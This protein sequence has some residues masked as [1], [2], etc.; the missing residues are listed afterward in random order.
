MK[1]KIQR[2]KKNN[3][4]F[5]LFSILTVF[6]LTLTI[7]FSASSSMLAINGGALVRSSADVRIT[8]VQR[9]QESSDVTLKS[10]SLDSNQSFSLDCRLTTIWSKAYFEITVTNLSSTP[11]LV[12]G[13]EKLQELNTHMDYSM[14]DFVINKTKIPPASEAKI[15]IC[16]QYK[17]DFADKYISGNLEI[18][19]QW[20]NPE[21]SNLKTSLKLNFY[22]VPQYNYTINTN[23]TD[24]LITLEDDSGVIATGNG[25]LTSI[26]DEN[27]TVKWTVTRKNYYP[28]TGTEVVTD[29]VVKEITMLRT[30]DKIFT[31]VPTP[32]DALVTIKKKS[33]DTVLASGI[34]TQSIAIGDLTELSYSV[35]RLE[36][37]EVTGEYTLA[38]EDYTENV[39]LEEMP[40]AT[41]TFVNTDRK[42]ETTKEDTIYHP[43]YYLIEIWGGKG[44]SYLRSSSKSVGY[45]GTAG[46]I[47]GVVNLE[48][49]SKIYFTLGGDG[50]EG[51]LSGT[52]RGGANGGGYGGATYSG[53]AG[54]YS[55]FAI[56]TTTIDESN[57][58][59]G[60]VLLIVGGG[61]GGG[62][63]SL[64][65]GKPGDGGNAG[66][67][68]SNKT[69]IGIGTVFYGADGTLNDAKKGHNGLGGITTARTQTNA[70]DAGALLA[71]GNGSGNGG[72]GGAGYY[73]GG[74]GGG[75]GTLSSNQA[76]GGGGGSSLIANAVI[77]DSLSDEIKS[78]LVGT[79]PSETGGAIIITYLGKTIS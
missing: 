37:K 46:Y 36:Y 28:Q 78:K 73:G 42:V 54:G 6:I 65:A 75:A 57:I 40:W 64:V 1:K 30:E 14:G 3:L 48:Y 27:T 29:H 55:A 7:G 5:F 24:A 62:G 32:S 47:Y 50:R 70:G 10:L 61:G 53:G 76:G 67:M 49:N 17:S 35:S 74:G 9:V 15:I 2:N 23:L 21:T 69:V 45:G 8:N 60:N 52:S 77:Y 39:T 58:N 4:I 66:S 38:G 56:N 26:V 71:G 63:S 22:R 19:E 72:G 20:R 43:G 18:L 31:V 34:G 11:V 33:D 68:D 16:F 13:I 44:G 79:N 41:G 12:T 59:N 51:E 25:S